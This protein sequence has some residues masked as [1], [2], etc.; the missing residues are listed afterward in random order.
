MA[1][2]SVN[3]LLKAELEALDE[4]LKNRS[5]TE[6][7]MINIMSDHIISSGGKRLRPI[8]LLLSAYSVNNQLESTIINSSV[9][10][11]FIHAATLL[12]DDVV[13]MSHIR[14]NIDTA[15]TI[16]GNKGAVL[17][18]DFLYSRAF[19]IIVEINSSLVYETLAQT[20]NIIAQ[21]EVMQLMNIGNIDISENLY[22]DIIFRKT[23]ILFQASMKIGAILNKGSDK[24]IQSLAAFGL[25]FGNAYQMRNDYLDYFGNS[26]ST[27]KNI[28]EDLIEGKATLPII[29]VMQNASE[30]DKKIIKS[31]FK[32]ADQSVADIIINMLR[33]Y[34]ADIFMDNK[35]EE[36]TQNAIGSLNQIKSSEYKDKLI[37]L[38]SY[39]MTRTN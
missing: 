21:G 25:H 3:K 26:E 22:M 11:E 23:S 12:H 20:T 13:D 16:W 1:I 15:H 30:T 29:H 5:R 9:V 7:E 31:S 24:E 36:Q 27:G 19:E 37:E 2:L 4:Q 6:V 38:A 18:G 10:V 33:K 28:I 17:V 32:Q 35:I 14:H 39:C 8:T 34:K